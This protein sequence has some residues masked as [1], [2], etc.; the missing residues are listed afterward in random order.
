MISRGALNKSLAMICVCELPYRFNCHF[1]EIWWKM[2]C[3]FCL[4]L[5][6]F[7]TLHRR[8]NVLTKLT[9]FEML[10]IT[11]GIFDVEYRFLQ[12]IKT[13]IYIRE[14]HLNW[15]SKYIEMRSF[16]FKRTFEIVFQSDRN[17]LQCAWRCLIKGKPEVCVSEVQ[18]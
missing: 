13:E 5:V 1:C 15:L 11:A 14:M 8:S 18:C 17:H 3:G 4:C 12:N 9:A 6:H 7:I 16:Q 2:P 10:L